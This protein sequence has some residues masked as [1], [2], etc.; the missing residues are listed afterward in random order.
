MN[1][2]DQNEYL[3]ELFKQQQNIMDKYP[4]LFPNGQCQCGFD[5]GFG[6]LPL[7]D[8]LC[9]DIVNVINNHPELTGDDKIVEVQQI[10]QKFSSMRFYTGSIHEAMYDEVYN[11][12]N[13]AE[14]ASGI[15][16]E[17]CGKPGEKYTKRS[18]IRTLC[19]DCQK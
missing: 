17:D 6:W 11:L 1:I 7:I 19:K 10:K 3:K 12:I 13:A 15:I 9:Q 2:N 16:C 5:V 8:N 14:K 18:W 4:Q